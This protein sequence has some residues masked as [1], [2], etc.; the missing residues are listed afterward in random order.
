MQ[1]ELA[2]ATNI[3]GSKWDDVLQSPTLE[4]LNVP[5]SSGSSETLASQGWSPPRCNLLFR[6]QKLST[7]R[8]P[9]GTLE[10]ATLRFMSLISAFEKR[11]RRV[12]PESLSASS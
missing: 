2:G 7:W 1:I 6:F 5:G 11:E 8:L 4:Q 3:L 10:S 9:V 12:A